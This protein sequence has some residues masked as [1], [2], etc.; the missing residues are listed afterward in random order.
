[1]RAFH[2]AR[3]LGARLRVRARALLETIW[4]DAF[5]RRL[6]RHSSWG[7]AASAIELVLSLV[8]TTLVARALGV[9]DYGQLALVLASIAS[10]KQFLDVRAWEGATRY[11]AEFL[12][13]G[14]RALALATLKL[15]LLADAAV[16]VVAYGTALTLAG[17]ISRRWLKQPDLHGPVL[18]YAL[19]LLLTAV[20]ATG[21]AVLRVFERFRDLAIRATAQALWHLGLVATVVLTGAHVRGLI[22]AYLVSDLAG[23]VLLIALAGRQVR[24]HLWAARAEARLGALRPYLTEMLSFTAHTA[25]RATLKLNR[26]LDLLVLGHF[27]PPAE[28]GYYRIARRLGASAVEMSNPFYF[29]IFPEFARAWAGTPRQFGRVVARAAGVAAVAAIPGV[30]LGVWLAPWLIRMWVGA[31]YA[32]AAGPFRVVMVGMGL[33]VA[34]FWGTPAALGSGR[35][36]MAT[37]AVACGVLVNLALLLLLAPPLG[38]T[39][40]AIGLLGSYVA[41][42]VVISALLVRAFRAVPREARA[43]PVGE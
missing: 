21:E 4:A 32:P 20:N 34:T 1:M 23:A 26:Q 3:T 35:P 8:E 12:Q 18:W 28:V 38:A 40:A 11:L 41:Y 16:A 31:A 5:L 25:A 29:V 2:A 27:R 19:T 36:G 43:S 39:G 6:A 30:L 17:L 22:V 7:L 42:A 24:A 15:A 13:R 14:E 37:C 33:A 9:T 10:V